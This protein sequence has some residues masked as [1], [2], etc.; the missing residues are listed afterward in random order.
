MSAKDDD[1]VQEDV[2]RAAEPLL[3]TMITYCHQHPGTEQAGINALNQNFLFVPSI[4][5]AT[6]RRIV[7]KFSDGVWRSRW[8]QRS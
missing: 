7:E 3:Q 1:E 2:L 6:R 8:G 4:N 5:A